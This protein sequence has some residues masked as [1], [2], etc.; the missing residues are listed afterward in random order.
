MGPI[1]SRNP[2]P[3]LSTFLAENGA[4]GFDAASWFE[5][6]V[7]GP[8]RLRP[9]LPLSTGT[10][11]R[12]FLE[13]LD[14]LAST[15]G[16]A[17]WIEKT[18]RHLRYVPLIEKVSTGARPRFIHV[19]RDGL[20]VVASL[21]AASRSWER[22]YDLDDCVRRW[23]ADVA[24]SLRRISAAGDHLLLYEELTSRPEPTIRRLL[25]DLG[26][27]WEPE[28]LQRYGRASDRLITE[29]E[30]WKADV[31]RSIRPSGTSDRV[32]TP[33]QRDRVTRALR[34]DL[35]ERLAERTRRRS[36][37]IDGAG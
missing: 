17:G 2:T 10:V 22:P 3:G 24:F 7:P 1:L 6:M 15:R 12:G 11:A 36:E 21:H 37:S 35:S 16:A 26:L 32:L 5:S 34:R 23:N 28:I 30:S 29:E 19:V 14:R 20:E 31:G 4:D 27:G 18:P 33:P 8:F 13:L 9:L 25:G